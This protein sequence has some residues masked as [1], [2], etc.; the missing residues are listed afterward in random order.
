MRGWWGGIICIRRQKKNRANNAGNC[1]EKSK[2]CPKSLYLEVTTV[3]SFGEPPSRCWF[4]SSRSICPFIHLS[5]CLLNVFCFCYPPLFPG[6]FGGRKTICPL[7]CSTLCPCGAVYL[8]PVSLQQV[9]ALVQIPFLG[10][11]FCFG[12]NMSQV[13]LCPSYCMTA[14]YLFNF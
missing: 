14:G 2:N 13:I 5:I 7:E 3:D 1:E 4:S 12:K 9:Q 6:F 11:C 8:V 10:F